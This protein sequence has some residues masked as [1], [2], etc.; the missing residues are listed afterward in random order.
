M[1][2]LKGTAGPKRKMMT[3]SKGGA[4]YKDDS[5]G[6]DRRNVVEKIR[7]MR[8]VQRPKKFGKT[9]T[10]SR[11]MMMKSSKSKS[12]K[13]GMK[14]MSKK[15]KNGMKMGKS[16]KGM[17]KGKSKKSMKMGKSKKG[18]M[19][20]KKGN[21]KVTTAPTN[22][23]KSHMPTSFPIAP[24]TDT[25]S[26]APTTTP[27]VE[28]TVSPT[29]APTRNPS[30]SPTATPTREPTL[31]TT[32]T[33]TTSPS[34][35]P[36]SSPVS[37]STATPTASPSSQPTESP[38]ATSDPSQA[39]V[40]ASPTELPTALPNGTP[41]ATPTSFPTLQP[42][43]L[44]TLYPTEPPTG[45]PT[46]SPV[47]E[48]TAA[49]FIAGNPDLTML[50]TALERAQLDDALAQ[51]RNITMFAPTDTGFNLVPT[52]FLE[53]LFENDSFLPHLRNLL[54]YHIFQGATLSKDF[55]D[56][57]TFQA[58]NNE[59]I[60]I[61]LNPLRVNSLVLVDE[62]NV[63]SNGVVHTLGGVLAPSWVFSN[64]T[65]R[66]LASS[67]LDTFS[68]LV[69]MTDI[70]LSS[71]NELTV[72]APTNDAFS[73]LGQDVLD[74]LT[75][76]ANLAELVRVLEYHI[77]V[78][79]F[80]TPRLLSSPTLDTLEG[81]QITV[82]VNPPT[83]ILFNEQAMPVESDILANNGVLHQ[84]NAVLDPQDGQ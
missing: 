34:F 82:T 84:I 76:P 81:G 72:L 25:P 39:P 27:T 2:T 57:T 20:G 46:S 56:A 62:D 47:G 49:S 11:P 63:V 33:P 64:L 74:F 3:R 55:Q 41:T 32:A 80:T 66:A 9:E 67:E 45:I 8:A 5:G 70:D 51:P 22:A 16:N 40:F 10:S 1:R 75:D 31:P 43:T 30:T 42:T 83:T 61:R 58:L 68:S 24:P 13:K 26:I 19:T 78:G 36:T 79:V 18:M 15:S 53:L 60:A 23:P 77:I 17:K 65:A 48:Q 59:P 54:L 6:D 4:M 29:T 37:A 7:G 14:R 44:P 69:A 50:H 12:S 71:P 21:G 52:R 35:D 28:S 38:V 73:A